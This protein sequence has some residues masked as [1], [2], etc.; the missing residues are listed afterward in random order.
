MCFILTA[1]FPVNV[2]ESSGRS[3]YCAFDIADKISGLLDVEMPPFQPN[4]DSSCGSSNLAILFLLT[5]V[6]TNFLC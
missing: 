4:H 3:I 1:S 5:T 2:T 6:N